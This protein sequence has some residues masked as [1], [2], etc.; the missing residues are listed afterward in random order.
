MIIQ[1][2]THENI[3]PML[4]A[5][6]QGKHPSLTRSIVF[7]FKPQPL[8]I[9]YENHYV[10]CKYDADLEG[11]LNSNHFLKQLLKCREDHPEADLYLVCAGCSIGALAR[12]IRICETVG[13]KVRWASSK[14]HAFDNIIEELRHPTEAL[15]PSAIITEGGKK[16]PFLVRV[17]AQI[18]GVSRE[19]AYAFI[20]PEWECMADIVDH[21]HSNFIDEQIEA[22]F[23]RNM[24]V[25]HETI[26]K[27]VR[28]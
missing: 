26:Y 21:A 10:E 28:G 13:V 7:D 11:S 8:D 16:D 6:W 24:S 9:T 19:F 1:I 2:D 12:A 5:L 22:F 3:T 23:Q 14:Q 20:Q 25:L 4:A 17:F 18:K 27:A 15:L